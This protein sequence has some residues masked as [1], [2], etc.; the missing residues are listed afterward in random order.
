MKRITA[1]FLALI[2]ISCSCISYASEQDIPLDGLMLWVEADSGLT[3]DEDGYIEKWEDKSEKGNDL[4]QEDINKQPLKYNKSYSLSGE[5]PSV[6]FETSQSLISDPIEY[7]GSSTFIIYYKPE[8]NSTDRT[9]FSSSQYKGDA[10]AV[11]GEIPFMLT[12]SSSE[13]DGLL[14]TMTEEKGTS[15]YPTKIPR[16]SE[17]FMTAMLV[18][19]AENKKVSVYNN[20]S[21]DNKTIT[22]PVTEFSVSEIPYYESFALGL[23]YN[24]AL[25]RGMLS[26]VGAVMIYDRALSVD[27]LNKVNKYLKIKYDIPEDVAGLKVLNPESILH[28]GKTFTPD[29]VS[30]VKLMDLEFETKATDISII[31]DN[32][33]VITVTDN[34]TIKAIGSGESLITISCEE[35][36]STS[37]Y[38]SV[39]KIIPDIPVVTGFEANGTLNI[40]QG[41]KAQ[42]TASAGLLAAIY[43]N[44]ILVDFNCTEKSEIEGKE[45][46][47]ISFDLTNDITDYQLVIML[48]DSLDT[49]IPASKQFLYPTN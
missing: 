19:D 43:K 48:V 10:T 5:Q 7:S 1:I 34:K 8:T 15:K 46:L 26:E 6:A 49:M 45:N 39:P 42:E 27:E 40:V 47:E 25:K 41:V 35:G 21:G 32:T 31:S 36:Y 16:A 24:T 23:K 4:K 18:I 33:D 2:I 38:V 13:T 30:V 28:M 11:S 37:F 29:V 3:A 12:N 20:F 9:V 14:F 44:D 22:E 17:K